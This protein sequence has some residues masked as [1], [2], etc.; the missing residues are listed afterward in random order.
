[1]AIDSFNHIFV[2]NYQDQSTGTNVEE[3][4]PVTGA[5]TLVWSGYSQFGAQGIFADRFRPNNILIAFEPDSPQSGESA[6]LE[7]NNRLLGTAGMFFFHGNLWQ[8]GCIN[9]RR[10]RPRM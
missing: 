8:S 4:D 6:I 10:L 3:V 1:M 7:V 2:S 5:R 9:L